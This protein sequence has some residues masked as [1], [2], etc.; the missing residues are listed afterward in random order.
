MKTTYLL[1]SAVIA[2]TALVNVANADTLLSP[3]AEANQIRFVSSGGDAD[4]A[5]IPLG[6]AS[7]A[8]SSGD[9]SVVAS[10]GIKD[11]DLARGLNS[12]GLAARSK[13]TGGSPSG[14]GIRVAPLK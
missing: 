11:R 1:A 2:A 10:G 3:R 7:R 8:K 13:A 14:A 5:R 12:L 6:A 9:H 4:L